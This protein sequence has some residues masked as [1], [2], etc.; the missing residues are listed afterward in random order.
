M[1]KTG[2]AAAAILAITALASHPASSRSACPADLETDYYSD[3]THTVLV[4][5]YIRVC[6]G[7]TNTWGTVTQYSVCHTEGC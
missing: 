6:N 3:A 5:T 2:L 7:H 1:K 4:G